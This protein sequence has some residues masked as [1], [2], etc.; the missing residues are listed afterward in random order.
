MDN[1]LN[2]VSVVDPDLTRRAQ[3][4]RILLNEDIRAEPFESASE[5]FSYWGRTRSSLVLIADHGHEVESVFKYMAD[6]GEWLPTIVYAKTFTPRQVVQVTNLGAVGFLAWPFETAELLEVLAED[7]DD[8]TSMRD[9]VR[10]RHMA[11]ARLK[12]LTRRQRE[13]AGAVA[14]GLTSRQIAE[15]LS[16]SHRTVEIHRKAVT[17]KLG[18]TS[19]E[20]IK[21]LAYAD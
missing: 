13:I 18:M 5:L 2:N 3:V 1:H 15:R 16:I 7:L 17:D 14:E 19:S 9:F 11:Q 12:G 10:R 4:C 21:L 8:A 20:V 6:A